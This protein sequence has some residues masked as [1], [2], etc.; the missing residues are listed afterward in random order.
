MRFI[1]LY[2]LIVL[3]FLNNFIWPSVLFVILFSYYYNPLWLVPMAILL[4][5]YFG[6]FMSVP[7]LSIG[8]IVWCVFANF[9]KSMML[10]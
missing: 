1:S 6:N 10:N 7:I 8:I 9:I 4:D 3:T 2:A 5:G